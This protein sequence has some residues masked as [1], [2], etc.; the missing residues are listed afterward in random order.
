MC[1]FNRNEWFKDSYMVELLHIG[2]PHDF[3]SVTN[4]QPL[5][6]RSLRSSTAQSDNS[7]IHLELNM[8]ANLKAFFASHDIDISELV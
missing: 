3:E 5:S 1:T 2:L 4:Q 6:A 7:N 8:F